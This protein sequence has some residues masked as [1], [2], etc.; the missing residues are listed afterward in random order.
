MTEIIVALIGLFGV[1]ITALFG[2]VQWRKTHRDTVLGKRQTAVVTQPRT[3]TEHKTL[4]EQRLRLI[5]RLADDLRHVSL[6]NRVKPLDLDKLYVQLRIHNQAPL[7]YLQQEDIEDL[8]GKDFIDLHRLTSTRVEEKATE[9]L[10]PEEALAKFR[11]IVVLG[12]PGAGKTTMLRY[13]ALQAARGQL[14]GKACL[15]VLVELRRF[16][17]MDVPDLLGY[18]DR[19]WAD[20]YGASNAATLVDLVLTSGEGVLLL[21]GLDE[22][23]G[24]ESRDAADRIYQKVIQEID[25]LAAR[26]PN[27]RIAVTC[28]RA[29]WRGQL[30]A[31]STLEVLDFDDEQIKQFIT[32]WFESD[33][34]RA[35]GLTRALARSNRIHKLSS[36]P[37][38][39]SLIA[40]VYESDLELPERRSELYKRTISVLLTEW[41][42][43]RDIRRFA[44]FTS[45]RKRDLLEEVA[46]NFHR[47]GLA[48]FPKGELLSMIAEFLPTIA[49]D[50]AEAPHI[51][52]EITEQYGLLKEQAHEVYGFVHLTLQEYFAAEVAARLGQAAIEMIS[53]A[54]HD[55]WWEEVILLLSG[56]LHDA[57]PLLLA[58]LCRISEPAPGE[59]LAAKDDMFHSDLF[60]TARCLVGVPRIKAG[61]LRERVLE[62]VKAVMLKS[63]HN[64]IYERAGEL[65]AEICREIDLKPE[66]IPLDRRERLVTVLGLDQRRFVAQPNVPASSELVAFAETLDRMGLPAG[67]DLDPKLLAPLAPEW[68][69][70]LAAYFAHPD[71]CEALEKLI[72][73][74]GAEEITAAVPALCVLLDTALE[75]SRADDL[76]VP[77]RKA[78]V[79]LGEIQVNDLWSLLFTSHA[80]H[81][82]H[83]FGLVKGLCELSG[84]G[85]WRRLLDQ[86]TDVRTDPYYL[87]ELA[88]GLAETRAPEMLEPILEIIG[89]EK[90]LWPVRWLLTE[91]LDKFDT[92][93][94][95]LNLLDGKALHP[96]VHMGIAAT[97]TIQGH[98]ECVPTLLDAI[99]DDSFDL[100]ARTRHPD[101][102]Y[103]YTEVYAQ[104]LQ[105][106][107]EA[108]SNS[109]DPTVPLT[110]LTCFDSAIATDPPTS[111][112]P[113]ISSKAHQLVLA[114][115]KT[116][117][118]E[119]TYRLLDLI[120][121]LGPT[122]NMAGMYN[123][124]G[125][126]NLVR[127]LRVA[128]PPDLSAHMLSG[129]RS[130]SL[131]VSAANDLALLLLKVG[132]SASDVATVTQ[133][134]EI[135][136]D[137]KPLWDREAALVALQR[138]S[139]R[140]KIRISHDWTFQ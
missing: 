112:K 19:A 90:I 124:A 111:R 18:V 44:R 140:A 84:E 63:P 106:V 74:A 82:N 115:A 59:R 20:R 64:F 87:D 53:V 108:L 47:Q 104:P 38:L 136:A 2:Y 92:R 91:V 86:L 117:P 34:L 45:D 89:D 94:A 29:G 116:A 54:R 60:L 30:P 68:L 121:R 135:A 118:R 97:L 14:H 27:A 83:E 23:L 131:P 16:V 1:L 100:S 80:S 132:D 96:M 137:P 58:L 21:D 123:L 76:L 109:T 57:T 85:L 105:R 99:R 128:F 126:N 42:A 40:I 98:E 107:L 49:V 5:D 69:Q 7:R 125:I 11:R 67:T 28:R 75:D 70:R 138:V 35:D 72:E 3:R 139:R 25:R 4:G 110:L 10:T 130:V 15:P 122:P 55:P 51:L 113:R 6:L 50:S 9:P 12:D 36:N 66:D 78:L 71:A 31:F 22:V 127:S 32:H 46:W 129:L 41:D 39:L 62:A 81:K 56:R 101:S 33:P 37:L 65:L 26:Y 77:C 93:T 48:Y 73:A 102:R 17:R 114:L 61:W 120:Q 52:A 95:L 8:R 79:Q 103:G 13:L 43:H 134:L 24:G 133:L 119:I 88:R